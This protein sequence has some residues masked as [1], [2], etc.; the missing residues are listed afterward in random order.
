[1]EKR[2]N[3][4]RESLGRK[5]R[6]KCR[7]GCVDFE[8]PIR[9]TSKWIHQAGKRVGPEMGRLETLV[10]KAARLGETT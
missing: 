10:L 8:M 7:F 3:V 4:S 2:K 5:I 6:N 1:M 9:Q